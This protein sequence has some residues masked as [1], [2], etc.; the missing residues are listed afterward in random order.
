MSQA[1]ISRLAPGPF[2]QTYLR[3][4]G[5][6]ITFSREGRSG[7]RMSTSEDTVSTVSIV[8]ADNGKGAGEIPSFLLPS[9]SESA[10]CRR[11]GRC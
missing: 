5:I 11:C 4:L 7:T 2:A 10:L 8:G 9:R 3:T 1:T 6:Q